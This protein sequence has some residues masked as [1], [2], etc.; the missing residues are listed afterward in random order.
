MPKIIK[1]LT[2]AKVRKAKPKENPYKL[3]DEG[4]LR[5]LIRPTGVKVWQYPYT[6]Q[7]K[8]NT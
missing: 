6:L 8:H 5:L 3:C 1:K 4:G 2:D 7:G